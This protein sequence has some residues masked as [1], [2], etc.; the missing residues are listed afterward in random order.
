MPSLSQAEAAALLARRARPVVVKA[1]GELLAVWCRGRLVNAKNQS[2]GWQM[3]AWDRYKREWRERVAN[4]LLEAGWRR[5]LHGPPTA[6]IP[7]TTFTVMGGGFVSSYP[8]DCRLPKRIVFRARTHGKI[9]S[10][11]LQLALAPVRD[12]LIDCGVIHN[13]D[14]DCGHEFIYE[15]CV[16][17]RK[18]RGVEIRVS[19]R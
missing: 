18:H 9:D 12:G 16:I 19:L 6:M 4:A 13:D 1:P 5:V 10:D 17:D 14:R 15:P 8:I 7:G 2:R 3:K 11:G